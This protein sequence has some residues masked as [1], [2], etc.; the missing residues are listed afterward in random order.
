MHGGATEINNRT[1]TLSS[2][3]KKN[4][5][6]LILIGLIVILGFTA[7]SFFTVTNLLNILCN[8]SMPLRP[9][10]STRWRELPRATASG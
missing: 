3:A 10:G 6:E 4:I 9:P 1:R 2:Y 8:I 7:P 5:M